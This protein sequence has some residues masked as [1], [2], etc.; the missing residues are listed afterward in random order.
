MDEPL[1][2]FL[3]PEHKKGQ[4]KQIRDG[5][6]VAATLALELSYCNRDYA[7]PLPFIRSAQIML[8]FD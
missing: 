4:A 8:D 5:F 6:Y 7:M 1:L 2:E 3:F